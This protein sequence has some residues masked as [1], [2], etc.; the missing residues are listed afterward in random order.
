MK[1]FILTTSIVSLSLLS[2]AQIS[3]FNNE[4]DQ[5]WREVYSYV[6]VDENKL[7]EVCDKETI[8]TKGNAIEKEG[9]LYF[10]IMKT[11]NGM[12]G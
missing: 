7:Q 12:I 4:V 6:Y 8:I 11:E 3:L 2:Q 5:E 9:V 10:P 1:K